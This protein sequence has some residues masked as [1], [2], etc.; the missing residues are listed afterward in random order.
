MP[1]T[2]INQRFKEST[3]GVINLKKKPANYLLVFS[4]KAVT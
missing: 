3:I 2:P 4:F 1:K